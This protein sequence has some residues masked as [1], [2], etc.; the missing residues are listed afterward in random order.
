MSRKAISL[1]AFIIKTN[2]VLQSAPLPTTSQALPWS[3]TYVP[4]DQDVPEEEYSE[5]ANNAARASIS[6]PE[7]K[8]PVSP[9]RKSWFERHFGTPLTPESRDPRNFENTAEPL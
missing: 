8:Q 2:P 3:G 5:P 1:L 4:Y 9:S 7:N 6:T